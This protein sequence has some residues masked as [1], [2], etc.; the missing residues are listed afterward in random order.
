MHQRR[1]LQVQQFGL[2]KAELAPDGQGE[3]ADPA[4][5]AAVDVPA[6]LGDL[7]E[8]PDGLQVGGADPRIPA[9]RELDDQQRPAKIA[10][11]GRPITSAPNTV[12]IAEMPTAT[13]S[14]HCTLIS[15]ASVTEYLA[16]RSSALMM[17]EITGLD[18]P[19]EPG[20]QP[21]TKSAAQRTSR[22]GQVRR[23]RVERQRD[24][25]DGDQPRRHAG[26]P[27][28]PSRSDVRQ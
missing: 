27:G 1:V 11:S 10:S 9:E 7:S 23:E 13:P 28:P 26:Q 8:R 6:H 18:Q 2:G 12:M 3:P 24:A 25:G 5:V 19:A 17:A 22:V 21:S 14:R 15:S 4:R 20:Q 16:R